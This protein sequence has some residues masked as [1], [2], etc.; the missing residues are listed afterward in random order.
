[1]AHDATCDFFREL[2]EAERLGIE[3]YQSA[4]TLPTCFMIRGVV[5]GSSGLARTVVFNA[6]YDAL[7]GKGQACGQNLILSSSIWAFLGCLVRLKSS[8]GG[9]KR[10]ER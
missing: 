9:G 7:P 10:C 5:S 3:V 2:K 4:Y 8:C 6:E 1:M